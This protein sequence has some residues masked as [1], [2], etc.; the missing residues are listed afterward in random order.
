MENNSTTNTFRLVLNKII[1]YYE[2]FIFFSMFGF[3]IYYSA[4]ADSGFCE[5]TIYFFENEIKNTIKSIDTFD[6]KT[7]GKGICY[8][9]FDNKVSYL[10]KTT[11]YLHEDYPNLQIGDSIS[12]SANTEDFRAYRNGQLIFEGVN[13][14]CQ[15]K[16]C[17][18]EIIWSDSTIWNEY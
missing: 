10:Y 5:Y 2:Y 4:N 15:C 14:P 9:F 1:S 12:K 17:E 13:L 18:K 8:Y 7:K 3:L 6:Y 11:Q 16:Y